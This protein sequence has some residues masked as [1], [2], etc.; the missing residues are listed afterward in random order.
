[1][2]ATEIRRSSRITRLIQMYSPSLYYELKLYEEAAQVEDSKE[3]FLLP[4]A[5]PIDPQATNNSIAKLP[6]EFG[7]CLKLSKVDIEGNKLT[8][9]PEN[10]L[11]SWT[12]LTELNAARNLLTTVPDSIGV[13][14]KLIRL[15]FHQNKISSIP[16]SIMGC[17]SLAEFYMGINLL[18]SLPQELGALS[19]LGTLDLHSNQRDELGL[20]FSEVKIYILA[21][22]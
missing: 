12:T 22:H 3:I 6:D 8:V 19:R 20:Q 9:I 18:S 17:C 21:P 11:R 5:S 14:T 15:D 16:S 2:P 1:M 13:L 7:K 10:V 4:N